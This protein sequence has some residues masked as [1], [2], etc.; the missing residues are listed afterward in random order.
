MM[1]HNLY[2]QWRSFSS[3]VVAAVATFMKNIQ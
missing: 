2:Y 3:R 1:G